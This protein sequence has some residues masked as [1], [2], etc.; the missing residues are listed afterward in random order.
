MTTLKTT[1]DNEW[2][3]ILNNEATTSAMDFNFYTSLNSMARTVR[4]NIPR[5]NPTGQWWVRPT[6]NNDA[7][8]SIPVISCLL[9]NKANWFL[10]EDVHMFQSIILLTFFLSFV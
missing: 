8:K 6:Q 10:K 7:S 2:Q 3:T 4:D 5:S 9:S 1:I